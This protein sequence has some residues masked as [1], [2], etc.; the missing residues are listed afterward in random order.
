M[1]ESFVRGLKKIDIKNFKQNVFIM[2]SGKLNV[3]SLYMAMIK[4]PYDLHS[5]TDLLVSLMGDK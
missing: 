2:N 5:T 3:K 1:K 4:H